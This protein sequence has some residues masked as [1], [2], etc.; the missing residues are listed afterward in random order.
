MY[1]NEL[2][3]FPKKKNSPEVCEGTLLEKTTKVPFWQMKCITFIFCNLVLAISIGSET[4]EFINPAIIA[5]KNDNRYPSFKTV[6]FAISSFACV[7]QH[8]WHTFTTIARPIV[9]PHP[10]QSAM[11]PSSETIRRHASKTLYGAM[12]HRLWYLKNVRNK[13]PLYVRNSSLN[14]FF[15]VTL[16]TDYQHTF[17]RE[18][19]QLVFHKL[20]Q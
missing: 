17:E 7:W 10:V 1:S 4:H 9:G 19:H 12:N 16:V 15:A 11:I 18:R 8:S 5:P 2:I 13:L 3:I 20:L 6:L 14:N